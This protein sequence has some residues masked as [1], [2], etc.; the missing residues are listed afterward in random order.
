[1]VFYRAD[2]DTCENASGSLVV[3]DVLRAF[4][5]AAYAFGAR[6]ERI[7]LAGSVDEAFAL[8]K[9]FPE[10]RLMGEAEGLKVD[11]FDYSN[12]PFEIAGQNLAGC[13]LIQRTS[14]GTQGVVRS[15]K[16]GMLLAASFCCAGATARLIRQLPEGDVTFVITGLGQG[17]WGDEDAACADYL[18]SLLKNENTDSG[19][20]LRRVH[21]S[22]VGAKF[23]DENQPDFPRP[24]IDL[25]LA[26][27]AFHFAMPVEKRHGLYE[28]RPIFP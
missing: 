25:C 11:G 7:T 3:I 27:D 9:R 12:S 16:A 24:D 21:D 17:G 26:L 4:S 18:E 14:A 19:P 22:L 28:M 20:Y 15:R 10:A 2:L 5:T 13:H 8:K 6:A 1:M 23:L